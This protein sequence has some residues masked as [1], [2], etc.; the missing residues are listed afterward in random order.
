MRKQKASKVDRRFG[1][2]ALSTRKGAKTIQWHN[3]AQGDSPSGKQLRAARVN[4]G[5]TQT[6]AGAL[7]G[8]TLN[9]WQR[10]EQDERTLKPIMWQLW[11]S[12]ARK[13]KT[14]PHTSKGHK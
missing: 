9:G 3:I 1:P 14:T 4:F 2:R 10:L 5:L 8:Y 13:I 7:I 6:Q 11:L 12:E